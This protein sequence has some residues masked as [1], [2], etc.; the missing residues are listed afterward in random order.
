MQTKSVKNDKYFYPHILKSC[1]AFEQR[2]RD[3]KMVPPYLYCGPFRAHA[4]SQVSPRTP[5]TYVS[6]NSTVG[7]NFW[8]TLK[9]PF[10]A[11]SKK[12]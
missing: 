11:V 12:K 3:S 10:P 5:A 7:T 4:E 1:V 2:T 6:T 8:Q 9:G